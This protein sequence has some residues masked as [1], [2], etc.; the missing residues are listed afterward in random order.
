MP[1]TLYYVGSLLARSTTGSLGLP[2]AFHQRSISVPSASISGPAL[3]SSPLRAWRLG[4]KPS[5][6]FWLLA[7]I[8]E[9][10]AKAQRRKGRRSGSLA[11]S[12]ASKIHYQ[13]RA[14]SVVS[15]PLCFKTAAWVFHQRS[16]IYIADERSSEYTHGFDF[17]HRDVP[18]LRSVSTARRRA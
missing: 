3:R 4:E 10:H 9:S 5:W 7:G 17:E 16:G 2:S 18:A 12:T 11:R 6:R 1:K 8:L 13:E 15:V 14:S